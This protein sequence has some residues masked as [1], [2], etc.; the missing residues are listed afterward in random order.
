MLDFLI[1][2]KL[3]KRE[4]F[5]KAYTFFKSKIFDEKWNYA[6]DE[7]WSVLINKYASSKICTNKVAYIYHS[8]NDSL[9]HNRINYNFL[10]NLISWFEMF[11]K[12]YDKKYEKYLLNRIS[13]LM[14]L[15]EIYNR[16][17]SLTKIIINNITLK[18]KYFSV[19]KYI[20]YYYKSKINSTILI[21]IISL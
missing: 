18:K 12:I 14:K 6:E 3:I 1:T 8:N 2:D 11:Q 17:Y 15:F 4:I 13:V 10:S 19:F 5:L 21:N 9:T 20:N 7:I 16:N